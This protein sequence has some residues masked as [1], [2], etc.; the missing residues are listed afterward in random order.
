MSLKTQLK[1]K[2]NHIFFQHFTRCSFNDP[3][4]NGGLS[5]VSSPLS[6]CKASCQELN[7]LP[8]LLQHLQSAQQ[9]FLWFSYGFQP[10]SW[11]FQWDGKWSRPSRPCHVW[12]PWFKMTWPSSNLGEINDY[13]QIHHVLM[14]KSTIFLDL[15]FSLDLASGSLR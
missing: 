7:P 2:K 6:I 8:V 13:G 5:R 4:C 3:W 9:V 14:G 11:S 10:P 15:F 12:V 1:L